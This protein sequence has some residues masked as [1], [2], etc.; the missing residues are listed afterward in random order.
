MASQLSSIVESGQHACYGIEWQLTDGVLVAKEVYN[1]SWR[2]EYAARA[3]LKSLFTTE[4]TRHTFTPGEGLVGQVFLQQQPTFAKDLQQLTEEENRA[5]MFGGAAFVYKRT[6]LAAEYGI[7]SCLFVPTKSG[8]LEVGAMLVVSPDDL[9]APA[10]VKAIQEGGPIP[11]VKPA[12][13]KLAPC[14][15]WLQKIAESCPEL[16]YAIEWTMSAGT[17]QVNESYNPAWRVQYAAQAGLPGLYTSSSRALTFQPGEGVV[18]QVFQAQKELFIQDAQEITEEGVRDDMFSGNQVHFLRADMAKTF[19]IRSAAFVP[20][21]SGVLEL[22]SM[23]QLK[24]MAALL[25]DSTMK[26]IE[27]AP[28]ALAK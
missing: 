7:H 18:G 15:P 23:K 2:I 27:E 1:P 20:L 21:K 26:A 24:S 3:G 5:A 4:S 6:A 22:G 17:L 8:V 10:L 9:I 13:V 28:C 12:P 14:A 25:T 11:E 16:C 19:N